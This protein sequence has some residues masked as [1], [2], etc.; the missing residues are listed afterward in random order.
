MASTSGVTS[1]GELL[2]S[3]TSQKDSSYIIARWLGRIELQ[4]KFKEIERQYGVLHQETSIFDIF[5][6]EN[7]E[8]QEI[9]RFWDEDQAIPPKVLMSVLRIQA[10]FRIWSSLK[11]LRN[12]KRIKHGSEDQVLQ[13]QLV[14]RRWLTS[15]HI[16]KNIAH[17]ENDLKN[18][19]KFCRKIKDGY[20]VIIY[21]RKRG[22]AWKRKMTFNSDFSAII[23]STSLMGKKSLRTTSLYDVKKGPS[24]YFY[25]LARPTHK[26]WCFH[27]FV[28][29]KS[30][31]D[32][33]A[34]SAE[35]FK[36]LHAGFKTL[37]TLH[38][39]RS[40]FYIDENGVPR[41]AGPS[42]IDY[43]LKN[44][45]CRSEADHM[46]YAEALRQ[47]KSEYKTWN[48]TYIDERKEWREKRKKEGVTDKSAAESSLIKKK[49]SKRL[50]KEELEREKA[51]KE[52]KENEED[53]EDDDDYSLDD[54]DDV[55]GNSS[56]N[57]NCY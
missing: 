42:I 52:K 5:S 57:L 17:R 45:N 34:C 11:K 23:F 25:P 12:I 29:G 1:N 21:S 38:M 41:R 48:T 51:M 15:H 43:V 55:S 37:I 30:H 35:D 44:K 32:M 40:P 50:V 10:T 31:L 53:E 24:G 13:T 4:K 3:Y 49:S 47:L 56:L 16:A 22:Q 20:E 26:V 28:L 6:T 46:R 2:T 9:A 7:A 18:F 27:L 54:D 19:E 39:T 8:R 33:E 36:E 14:F